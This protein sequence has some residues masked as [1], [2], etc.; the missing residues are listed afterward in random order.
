[1]TRE[2]FFERFAEG[3]WQPMDTLPWEYDPDFDEDS[4]MHSGLPVGLVL[5]RMSGG[6][7]LLGTEIAGHRTSGCDCC[8]SSW[9]YVIDKYDGWQWAFSE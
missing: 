4:G 7:H 2:K 8:S 1:M 3:P 5:R 6:Y 9:R